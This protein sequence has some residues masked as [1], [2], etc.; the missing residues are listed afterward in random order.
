MAYSLHRF[1]SFSV[2]SKKAEAGKPVMSADISG[3]ASRSQ[4]AGKSQV[5]LTTHMLARQVWT[6]RLAVL[7]LD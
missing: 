6:K 2:P 3:A 5:G 4:D 7:N 1:C